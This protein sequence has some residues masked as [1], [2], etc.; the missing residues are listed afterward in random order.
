MRKRRDD[1]AFP[2]KDR[3]SGRIENYLRSYLGAF[4]DEYLL[5]ANHSRISQL[6][7]VERLGAARNV[8]R[9]LLGKRGDEIP[10]LVD[11]PSADPPATKAGLNCPDVNRAIREL[12]HRQSPGETYGTGAALTHQK[13]EPIELEVQRDH[14]A[15]VHDDGAGGNLRFG[16]DSGRRF[17]FLEV[18]EM[19]RA[20]ESRALQRCRALPPLAD[21]R[22]TSAQLRTGARQGERL[23]LPRPRVVVEVE[24]AHDFPRLA[25]ERDSTNL[26]KS[27]ALSVVVTR[28]SPSCVTTT[29]SFT[30][31]MTT[32][33][34]S[35]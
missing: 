27:E 26:F 15:R 21:E 4:L 11:P 18:R 22:R 24:G 23:E 12:R 32:S 29:K 14:A 1:G 17:A 7:R 34:D 19:L 28:V 30:P 6:G 16:S 20:D 3:S 35:A 9:Q 10:D 25:A 8:F 33:P 31:Y 5:V 13:V 2:D